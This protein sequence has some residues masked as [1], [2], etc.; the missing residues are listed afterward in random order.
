MSDA[1]SFTDYSTSCTLNK[2]LQ[3]KYNLKDAH[4]YR[5]F[6]QNN[7]K[8]LMNNFGK[9]AGTDCKICPECKLALDRI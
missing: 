2:F 6:L 9:T 3:D 1:R 8:V 7:A 4:E 5:Y